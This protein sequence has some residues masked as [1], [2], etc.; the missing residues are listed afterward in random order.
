MSVPQR[1]DIVIVHEDTAVRTMLERWMRKGGWQALG[2]DSNI[3]SLS[4]R[5][6]VGVVTRLLIISDAVATPEDMT[7]SQALHSLKEPPHGDLKI[8]L[9][10][11]G[12]SRERASADRVIWSATPELH[13]ALE[14]LVQELLGAPERRTA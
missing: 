10:D 12:T 8:I 14:I 3:A 6:A 11:S 7:L 4:M 13:R 9:V 1:F 2:L 5:L